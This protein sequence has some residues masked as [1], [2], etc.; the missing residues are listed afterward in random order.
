L[1]APLPPPPPPWLFLFCAAL[2]IAEIIAS[3][4][5]AANVTPPITSAVDGA[6]LTSVCGAV[7][8]I[9]SLN[10]KGLSFFYKLFDYRLNNRYISLLFW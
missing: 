4:A 5:R 10:D 1:L 2:R 6:F 9:F 3:A 8:A 7:D